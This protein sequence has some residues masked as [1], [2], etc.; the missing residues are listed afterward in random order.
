LVTDLLDL[1]KIES[2]KTN[3]RKEQ[4]EMGLLI[5][6]I[7]NNYANEISK[8]QL[9]L[10]INIEQG[11]GPIQ[12]DRDKISQVIINLLNNAIKY[13]PGGGSITVQL[14]KGPDKDMRFEISD[15]GPGVAKEY[16]GKIFDKFE[17]VAAEKYEGTGLGLSIVKGIVE[18]HKGKIWIESEI[19]KG[20]KL[21][22][23]LP[24]TQG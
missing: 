24:K 6:E 16:F 4:F 22:F 17:R 23:I 2:G 9:T 3:M 19:G 13:T 15:T 21:I 8:K 12:A 7:L 10:K 20:S 5:T 18:L 1:A 14:A 11:I